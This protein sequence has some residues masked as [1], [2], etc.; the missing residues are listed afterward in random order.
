MKIKIKTYRN[1]NQSKVFI[2][3]KMQIKIY[4]SKN[5]IDN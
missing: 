1:N 2:K 5:E 3:A 4:Q